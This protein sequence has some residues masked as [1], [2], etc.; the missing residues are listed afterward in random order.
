[1]TDRE[2]YNLEMDLMD[3]ITRKSTSLWQKVLAVL[4]LNAISEH[5]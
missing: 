5:H 3:R 2:Y 4:E 1:M